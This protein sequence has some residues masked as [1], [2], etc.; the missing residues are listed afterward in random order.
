M[1]IS[2]FVELVIAS[3]RKYVSSTNNY[4]E[5]AVKIENLTKDKAGG[6]NLLT[7]M[8]ADD[9]LQMRVFKGE[10]ITKAIKYYSNW[11]SS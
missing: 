2:L 1:P 3:S 9:I 7:S 10:Q 5:A 8:L 4:L 6:L 11:S